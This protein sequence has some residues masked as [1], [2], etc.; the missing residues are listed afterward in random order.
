VSR[1]ISVEGVGKMPALNIIKNPARTSNMGQPS[2]NNIRLKCNA[3]LESR[4]RCTVKTIR[5][6]RSVSVVT[7]DS[8]QLLRG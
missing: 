4:G 3:L 6:Q 8:A 2:R 7:D 1:S 5:M